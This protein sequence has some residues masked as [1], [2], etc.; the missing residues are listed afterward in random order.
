M[1]TRILGLFAVLLLAAPMAA[2]AIVIY[3]FTGTTNYNRLVNYSFTLERP[4]FIDLWSAVYP[5]SE[6]SSCAVSDPRYPDAFCDHLHLDHTYHPG[7][8]FVGFDYRSSPTAVGGI[9]AGFTFDFGSFTTAGTHHSI[10]RYAE[11]NGT[12]IVTVLQ[13]VPEPTTLGL[14]GLG[15]AGLGMVRRRKSS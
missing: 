10:D 14:F 3:E 15:L 12:L 4:D 11:G 1:K 6:T 8:E 5:A 2:K 9:G 7:Y 13:D